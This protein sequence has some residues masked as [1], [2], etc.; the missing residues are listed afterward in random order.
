MT[1][2]HWLILILFYS[3]SILNG[4]RWSRI[5]QRE[6]YI[7]GSVIKF[8]IRWV[9]LKRLNYFIILLLILSIFLSL[10]YELASGMLIAT[11]LIF[12]YGIGYK[13]TT[14][15]IDITPRLKRLFIVYMLF[16]TLLTTLFLFIGL[17][18]FGAIASF[19]F[20]F[21]FFDRSLKLMF[22]I[23]KRLTSTFVDNAKEQ[24]NK[25]SGPVV[26][27]TGSYSK[28]TTKEVLTEI[29]SKE[30][31]VFATPNSYNNRLGIAKAIND[32]D[33]SKAEMAIIE[34]GTYGPGEIK[35]ICAWV[36]PHVAVITGIG[37]VHLERMK[38]Y[39]NILD[40]K[41]EIVDLAGSVVINGDD[42]MLLDKARAWLPNKQVIDC[43]IE[44]NEALVFV[45]YESGIH[46]IYIEGLKIGEI[47]A[48]EVHQLSIALSIGVL[49]VLD[50]DIHSLIQAVPKLSS[51][52][53]R[54]SI[55]EGKKQQKIIDN[56]F[57]SNPYSVL[58]S[59]K[60][61]EDTAVEESKLWLVTPGMVE[62]GSEQ[63]ALNVAFAE[64]A[65]KIVDGVF[66]VG[67]TNK[68]ALKLGFIDSEVEIYFV[69]KR[70]D[71]VKKLD[72]FVKE[73]DVVLFENDL[74]DHYP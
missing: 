1:S 53:H 57:N 45:N 37:P 12:P 69:E 11:G 73:N 35:D 41:S 16:I 58:S 55:L 32:S 28:T 6:H 62:L 22:N 56:T 17:G 19:L 18:Y 23:E 31:N 3:A 54:Q 60:L 7:P 20:S 27:I 13:A 66:I 2:L 71:A 64:E 67:L 4:L 30:N 8:Y 14:S 43:S 42:K 15:T 39:E 26:G 38:T 36:R 48:P 49:Y 50:L 9:K 59:L 21:F 65:S 72:S 74:P 33:L 44:S 25:L 10:M 29:L 24:I 63:F 51:V 68:R 5:A 61:L 47:Q 46:S 34:M 40:A 52:K 70:E